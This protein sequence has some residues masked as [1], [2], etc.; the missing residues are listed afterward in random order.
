MFDLL[1]QQNVPVDENTKAFTTQEIDE[2]KSAVPDWEIVEE[3]GEKHLRRRFEFSDFAAALQ[4]ADHIGEQAE[5]TN[6]HPK[7]IVEYGATTVELWT[8][9]VGGLHQND[10]NMALRID[11]L[12]SRWD[13]IS[14][15]K[16]VIQEAS[17]ESFPASDPPGWVGSEQADK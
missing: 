2:L 13:L 10:F 4:F 15:N 17:E 7:L 14:N 8:H 16:D 3:D 6:H 11:D 9:K 5:A 1:K 12:F